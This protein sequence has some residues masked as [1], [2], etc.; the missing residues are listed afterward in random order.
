MVQ[1]A[2]ILPR[3][4]IKAFKPARLAC[5]LALSFAGSGQALADQTL[6]AELIDRAGIAA[7]LAL[8]PDSIVRDGWVIQER[9]AATD[10]LKLSP[11]DKAEFSASVEQHFGL[12][13]SQARAIDGMSKNMNVKQLYATKKFFDSDLGERI[14]AA[15]SASKDIS[16]DEFVAIADEYLDSARW[17]K[18]REQLISVVYESTRAA[19]FVS[20]L[21]GELTVA[22]QVSSHCKPTVESYRALSKLLKT[23]RTD[24]RFVE[25]IMKSDLTLII[26]TIF[27][28]FSDRDLI[29]YVEFA[30]GDDGKSFYYALIE[31]TRLSISGGLE[32]VRD[33]RIANYQESIST[34]ETED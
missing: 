28:D 24:A 20:V 9:C 10:A 14:V 33:E 15:E 25:P 16:E 6:S 2:F 34:A 22:V 17:T 31:A 4:L 23:T 12:V 5:M 7:H 8:V 21:N 26:A 1:A 18:A 13:Q 27:R 11:L 19:R 29:E 3:P 30:Q 32:G